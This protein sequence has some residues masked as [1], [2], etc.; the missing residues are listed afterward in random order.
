MIGSHHPWLDRRRC[1]TNGPSSKF[2]SLVFSFS[3]L[4]VSSAS[5][6]QHKNINGTVEHQV[7]IKRSRRRTLSHN[8]ILISTWEDLK[9]ESRLWSPKTLSNWIQLL[10]MHE[11]SLKTIITFGTQRKARH[12]LA[13]QVCVSMRHFN[14]TRTTKN[15]AKKLTYQNEIGLVAVSLYWYV[16]PVLVRQYAWEQ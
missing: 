2:Q 8:M 14:S 16:I 7:G 9:N 3:S 12:N 6:C 1:T 15:S 4:M 11:F 5:K 13:L 10:R